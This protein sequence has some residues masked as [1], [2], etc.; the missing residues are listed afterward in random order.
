MGANGGLVGGTSIRESRLRL[1]EAWPPWVA[2]IKTVE[3]RIVG[4]GVL[5]APDTVL[6]A[7]HVVGEA[8]VCIAEFPGKQ[9]GDPVT[10][11]AATVRSDTCVPREVDEDGVPVGDLV[12]LRL[13]RPRPASVAVALHHMATSNL[14][15]WTYGFPKGHNGGHWVRADTIGGSGLDALMELRPLTSGELP[16]PGF[17][18]AAVVDYKTREAIGILL[19][20]AKERDGA[21]VA[22]MSPTDTIVKHL[23]HAGLYT[24]GTPAVDARLRTGGTELLDGPFAKRLARWFRGD[25][26]PVKISLV[27]AADQARSETLHRAINLADRELRTHESVLRASSDPPETVPRAGGH[28]LAVDAAGRTA[29]EIAELI[30]DR[31]GLWEDHPSVRAVDRI[32]T[33]GRPLTLVVVGV[34][35]AADPDALLDLLVLLRSQGSRLLLV[36]RHS[37]AL[38]GRAQR[39]LVIG[40]L[41]RRLANLKR[42]LA[43][44]TGPLAAALHEGAATVLADTASAERALARAHT[45]QGFLA[46]YPEPAASL[47]QIRD[48][49]RHE[50]TARRA[51]ARLAAAIAALRALTGQRGELTGLLHSYKNLFH[52]HFDETGSRARQ[53]SGQTDTVVAAAHLYRAAR[54][55]LDTLPCDVAAAAPAVRRY[56]DFVDRAIR[57][58]T[59]EH[60]GESGAGLPD[61][62]SADPRDGFAAGPSDGPSAGSPDGP[63]DGPPHPP[64]PSQ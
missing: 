2:R 62:P 21:G 45:L 59:A 63:V 31:A 39:E 17:S 30:V 61:G 60:A 19:S 6:T 58:H 53:S 1:F 9:P 54:R 49:D 26:Q 41:R 28:D 44:I 13:E 8:P 37:D 24:T 36:F 4:A 11:I 52:D 50:R 57:E 29:D 25:G 55:L 5:L 42:V 22:F 35:E 20:A 27:P 32:R 56:T 46:A 23:A 15:V 7:A 64:H 3:K 14:H 18:G 12:L 33:R 47:G 48:L 16:S 43:E 40:P 34:D 10:P 51:R 38:F